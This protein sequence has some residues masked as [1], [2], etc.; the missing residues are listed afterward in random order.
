M[1][2]KFMSLKTKWPQFLHIDESQIC[3]TK[4]G[5]NCPESERNTTE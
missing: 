5:F 2:G 1:M 3:K 4:N